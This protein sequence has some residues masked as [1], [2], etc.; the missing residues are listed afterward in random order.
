M[1]ARFSL[2]VTMVSDNGPQFRSTEMEQF[3][4]NTGIQHKF[5]APYHPAT[6][7]QAE[8]F[9]EMLKNGLRCIQN[10]QGDLIMKLN[11]LLM[12]YRKAPS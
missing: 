5:T 12:Q 10:E 7:G 2:P 4:K 9:E 8:R 3:T 1:F 11:R 6:N